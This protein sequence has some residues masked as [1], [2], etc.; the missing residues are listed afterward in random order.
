MNLQIEG[1]RRFPQEPKATAPL[2]KIS[3]LEKRKALARLSANVGYFLRWQE[4]MYRL[5]TYVKFYCVT[6]S[7]H[8]RYCEALVVERA[9][10]D[11][12]L[13][14]KHVIGSVCISEVSDKGKYHIHGILAC[15]SDSK[16]AK[17]RK[18]PTCHY[19]ITKLFSLDAW[20]EYLLKDK[21]DEVDL[22][23]KN[24]KSPSGYS[25]HVNL[26]TNTLKW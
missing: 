11:V 2:A 12:Y 3:A 8:S 7:P 23:W 20:C 5:N 18:H 10:K 16:W 15:L 9:M 22:R 13:K 1:N 21:P 17:L 26:V 14:Y 25:N 24:S 6:I 19:S 4:S